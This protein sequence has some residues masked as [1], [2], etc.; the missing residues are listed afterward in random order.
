MWTKEGLLELTRSKLLDYRFILVSNREPYVHSYSGGEI[1]CAQPAS[2]LTVA[3]DPIMR[4]CGGTWVAHGSGDADRRMVDAN[5]HVGVPPGEPR[6]TL[7]RVWLT[8]QQE[9]RYYYGLANQGLWPL[10]HIVFT[11][12]VFK[13]E[14]W[15][16]YREVNEAFAR[17]VLEEAGG[18]PSFVF[19]QDYH[20]G[21]LPRLLKESNPNLIVAQFWHIPWPNAEVFRGF[22]WKEELLDGLLGNDLLGFHLRQHCLNFLD[23]VDRTMEAKADRERFEVTRGG[24][25]TSV[26]PFPISIDFEEQNATAQTPETEQE[27]ARWRRRLGLRD[28]FVGIGI[29]RMDYTKGIAERLRALDRFLT[30]YPDYRE[31][32]VFVQVGVPSRTRIRQYKLLEE[33]IVELVDEINWKWA[34]GSWRPVIF[35]ERHLERV[36][37]AALHRLAHFAIVSSLHDGMNLVAKEYVGSRFD[38]D[39]VLILSDF[40]GASRELTDAII[41]NPFD[42]E[43]LAEAIRQALEMPE[44][45]RR[46]RMQK[47]REVVAENNIY[48][49]AGKII[50]ALLKFEFGA[51][52]HMDAAA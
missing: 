32:L 45:A 37:L 30:R 21:L 31:R 27:M 33:E 10:C 20:F 36:P 2:G 49:W 14:D 17:A 26:R 12:P 50:S 9:T 11:R 41:V 46:K 19:I 48:R 15:Q 22:P 3:L 40:T 28:E 13:P 6:F 24:R 1:E 44:E 8:K 29:D 51:N 42:E 16:A 38:G 47:M 18:A 34:A 5:S 23:T 7:R 35:I 4:A 43:E 39:G 52:G 25:T